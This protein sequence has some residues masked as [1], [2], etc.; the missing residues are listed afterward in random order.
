MAETSIG[1]GG[2]AVAAATTVEGAVA[3]TKVYQ[4]NTPS[5]TTGY[6]G[7]LENIGGEIGGSDVVVLVSARIWRHGQ[8]KK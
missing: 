2:A 8:R 4:Q 5:T 3:D 1:V 6:Q 7:V